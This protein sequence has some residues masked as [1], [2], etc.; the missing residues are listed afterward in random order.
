MK[1]TVLMFNTGHDGYTVRQCGST[2]TVGE[3][4]EILDYYTEDTEIFFKNDDG[5]TYGYLE[6]S[7]IEEEEIDND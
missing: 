2:M 6:E 5:Y 7:R 1:K 4:M 3:L